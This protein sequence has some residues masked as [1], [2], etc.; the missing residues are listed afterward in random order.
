[1]TAGCG[2]WVAW[3]THTHTYTHTHTHTH[4]HTHTHMHTHTRTHTHTTQ[5]VCLAS[6]PATRQPRPAP[7][8]RHDARPLRPLHRRRVARI[9]YLLRDA[10]P[11]LILAALV[12]PPP[13][14]LQ[15]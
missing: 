1:M 15:A 4:I 2:H 7:H 6:M 5:A 12:P 14:R 8:L 3:H 9:Q 11:Q 10:K 13:M